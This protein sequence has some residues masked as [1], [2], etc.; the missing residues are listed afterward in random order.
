MVL[1][2]PWEGVKLK[3]GD[4]AALLLFFIILACIGVIAAVFLIRFF[5]TILVLVL[6]LIIVTIMA[7]LLLTVVGLFLKV[8]GAVFYAIKKKPEVIPFPM[9]IEESRIPEKETKE[10]N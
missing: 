9:K 4:V 7:G 3:K 6:A 10:Q 2:F 5:P 8:F 1:H